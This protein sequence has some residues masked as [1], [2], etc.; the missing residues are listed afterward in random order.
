MVIGGSRTRNFKGK[1]QKWKGT[2]K[3]I[4]FKNRKLQMYTWANEW[5]PTGALSKILTQS[6]ADG[7]VNTVK[8]QNNSSFVLFFPENNVLPVHYFLIKDDF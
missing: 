7:V 3:F 4:H 5:V 2:H 6:G 1:I 8:N